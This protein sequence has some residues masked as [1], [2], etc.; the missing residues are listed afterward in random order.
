VK[1]QAVYGAFAEHEIYYLVEAESMAAIQKFLDSGW[2][3]CTCKI[4][5]V[6]EVPIMRSSKNREKLPW[7]E[8]A[9]GGAYRLTPPA[10]E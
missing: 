4:T 8:Y 9:W 7:I 5:P 6:S 10:F 2:T 3:R 1:L